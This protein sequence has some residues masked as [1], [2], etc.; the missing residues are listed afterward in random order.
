MR[1]RHAPVEVLSKRLQ[2]N[3]RRVNVVVDVVESLA[4][5]VAVRD[6]DR[7]DAG[8]L[9]GVAYVNDVFAPDRWLVVGERDRRAAVADRELHH[10]LRRHVGRPHLVRVRL[11]DVPVLAE[12]TAHVAAGRAHR[13]YARP[14]QKMVQRFFLDG[15]NLQCGRMRVPEAVKLAALVRANEAEPSLPLADMAV[16]RTKIAVHLAA[17][18]SLP[19][20]RFVE[21][22]CL[23][24]NLEILACSVAAKHDYTPLEARAMVR[25]FSPSNGRSFITRW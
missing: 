20:P 22:G 10:V 17:G 15:I 19:P 9:R 18:L 12:E 4:G 13:K 7:L 14:R 16:P 6:H 3:I 24:E 23:V 1:Q 2:V 8:F 21:F 25:G 5:D 11:R